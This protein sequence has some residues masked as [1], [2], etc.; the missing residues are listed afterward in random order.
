[1][2]NSRNGVVGGPAKGALVSI[3]QTSRSPSKVWF[4]QTSSTAGVAV[5]GCIATALGFANV[6]NAQ[7]PSIDIVQTCRTVS[8]VTTAA[9]TQQDVDYCLRSEQRALVQLTRSWNSFS[10]ADKQQCVRPKVYLPSY[11]EWLTCL[12]MERDARKLRNGEPILVGS[13]RLPVELPAALPIAY[14]EQPPAVVPVVLPRPRPDLAKVGAIP[15][16]TVQPRHRSAVRQLSLSTADRRSVALPAARTE[17]PPAVVPVVL[18]RPRPDL[19]KVGAVPIVTVQPRHRS[20]VRRLTLG[21]TTSTSASAVPRVG[22]AR[23]R[24]AATPQIQER[25][26]SGTDGRP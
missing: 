1:M 3:C 7:A 26:V 23:K 25:L 9:T 12:E 15:V 19:A 10:D 14:T 2:V 4:V 17:Q 22:Q 13:D 5:A 21:T 20:M 8:S 24:P 16:A 18:P 11:V 6:A